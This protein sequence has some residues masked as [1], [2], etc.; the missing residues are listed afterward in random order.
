VGASI[1]SPIDVVVV[2]GCL[3]D[4]DDG[5]EFA[6]GFGTVKANVP[7]RRREAATITFMVAVL[8]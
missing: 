2:T 8:N 1:T 4:H 7:D 6:V 3:G 5:R